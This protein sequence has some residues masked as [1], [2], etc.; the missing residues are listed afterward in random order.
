[1]QRAIA[2]ESSPTKP[3]GLRRELSRTDE[4]WE[5]S[6]NYLADMSSVKANTVSICSIA[7]GDREPRRAVRRD[8]S[9]TLI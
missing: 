5:P 9:N 2:F 4:G 8:L 6:G 1:M 3:S 7:A